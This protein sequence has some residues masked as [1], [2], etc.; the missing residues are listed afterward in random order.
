MKFI[1]VLPEDND[2]AGYISARD[3]EKE[4]GRIAPANMGKRYFF[5]QGA[6]ALAAETLMEIAQEMKGY[7][8]LMKK[9]GNDL[10]NGSNQKKIE[11]NIDRIRNLSLRELAESR[12]TFCSCDDDY[13][14]CYE[15]DFGIKNVEP[16]YSKDERDIAYVQAV[17]LEMKWLLAPAKEDDK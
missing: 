2:G 14:D 6:Y 10:M 8:D 3:E 15:G 11:R 1:D 9:R 12:I 16:P 17:E 7:E 13:H 5:V 4:L